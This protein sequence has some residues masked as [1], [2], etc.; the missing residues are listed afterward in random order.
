MQTGTLKSALLYRG[1]SRQTFISLLLEPSDPLGTAHATRS[2]LVP[3]FLKTLQR[4]ETLFFFSSF[5]GLPPDAP[6][7]PAMRGSSHAVL[8]ARSPLL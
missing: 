3:A 1:L 6:G 7:P 2:G 5:C 4:L 8:P